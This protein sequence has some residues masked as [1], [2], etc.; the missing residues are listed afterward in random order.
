MTGLKKKVY[1]IARV[2]ETSLQT[3]PTSNVMLTAEDLD[4]E[5]I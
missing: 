2:Q 3:S 1:T 4:A 5:P